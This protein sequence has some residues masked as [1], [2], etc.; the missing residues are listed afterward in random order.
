MSE[1][2][3]L[4]DRDKLLDEYA[5]YSKHPPK[6][7]SEDPDPGDPQRTWPVGQLKPNDLGLFDAYGNVWEWCQDRLQERPPQSSVRE[8]V[9]DAVLTVSDSVSRTR[10]SGGFPYGAAFMRSANRDSRN[11]FPNVRR[12]NVGFRVA[13]TVE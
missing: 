6:T 3:P 10:R 2:R 9:E 8:D 12:D 4:R 1:S 13:R 11:D 7:K 5:W